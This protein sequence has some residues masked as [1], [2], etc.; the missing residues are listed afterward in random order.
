MGRGEHL[1]NTY[2]ITGRQELAGDFFYI[3]FRSSISY[4]NRLH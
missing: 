4:G 2:K 1:F 3:C